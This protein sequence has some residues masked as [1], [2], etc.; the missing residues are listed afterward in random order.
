MHL[1]IAIVA[2]V[3][4]V[5]LAVESGRLSTGLTALM[6]ISECLVFWRD[7][8][9]N[10]M[11]GQDLVCVIDHVIMSVDVIVILNIGRVEIMRDHLLGFHIRAVRHYHRPTH[12][13][14]AEEKL[15]VLIGLQFLI[16]RA[17]CKHH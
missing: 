4:I 9:L 6:Q 7:S 10:Q 16:D 8:E 3:D 11:S 17:H 5:I 1:H 12:R 15:I 13:H 14:L 2:Q